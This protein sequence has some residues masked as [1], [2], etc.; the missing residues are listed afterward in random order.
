MHSLPYIVM[1][2]FSRE[3][4]RTMPPKR[5]PPIATQQTKR[6]PD[7]LKY[8]DNDQ[9]KWSDVV[10]APELSPVK[11]RDLLDFSDDEGDG[12]QNGQVQIEEVEKKALSKRVREHAEAA[13]S[14]ARD[15]VKR[16]G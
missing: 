5:W 11:I 7:K 2:E 10:V 15:F 14:V 13:L 4:F 9:L 3:H 6:N 16:M 1:L 12:G 8:S